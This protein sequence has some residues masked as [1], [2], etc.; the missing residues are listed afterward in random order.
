MY[1]ASSFT[2]PSYRLSTFLFSLS[3][4]SSH[5]VWLSSAFEKIE[6]IRVLDLRIIKNE[7]NI[8]LLQSD[9][10]TSLLFL[11]HSWYA[12]FIVDVHGRTLLIVESIREVL[13]IIQ[14]IC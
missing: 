2:T 4:P 14:Y 12:V 13:L 3:L 5:A 11:H 9:D 7:L 10:L 8:Y 1:S 6:M